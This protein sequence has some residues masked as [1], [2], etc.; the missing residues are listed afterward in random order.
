[1][2]KR[3]FYVAAITALILA[4]CATFP[5]KYYGLSGVTYTNGTLLGPVAADDLPFSNCAP[6]AAD[7]H[8][9]VVMFAQDFFAFKQDYQDTQNKLEECE[10]GQTTNGT[11]LKAVQ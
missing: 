11:P 1:M 5:Y 9:C 4:A 7:A 8:P 2:T 3:D 10:H 6:T